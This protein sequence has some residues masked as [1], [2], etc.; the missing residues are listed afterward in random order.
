MAQRER[1]SN[2]ELLNFKSVTKPDW[3]LS[4]EKLGPSFYQELTPEK[5]HRLFWDFCQAFFT[6][7]L[8]G[9][10]K[11][12]EKAEKREMTERDSKKPFETPKT[13]RTSHDP[14]TRPSCPIS[15]NEIYFRIFE[16]FS[17]FIFVVG[18]TFVPWQF[19]FCS[20]VYFCSQII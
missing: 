18:F 5:V 4:I 7:F 10:P 6:L 14:R 3:T 15:S 2:K 17:I 9:N 8:A 20:G 11:S 19:D 13:K 16:M 1:A 12:H